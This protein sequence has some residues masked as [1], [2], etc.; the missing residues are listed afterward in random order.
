M[1]RYLTKR[2]EEILAFLI[3]S[4]RD[5]GLPPTITEICER[6]NFSSTNAAHCH[7]RALQ[8]K[9][10]ILRSEKKARD[11]TVTP[12][13]STVLYQTGA[14][15]APLV[16]HVAAGVP[17]LA[18]ENIEDHVPV[19]SD[20]AERG[21]FCLRVRGDSMIEAGILHGDIVVVDHSRR[22]REGDI[23]VALV[24]DDATVKYYHPKGHDIILKPANSAMEPIVADARAVQIQGVVVALQ[25]NF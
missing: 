6:F 5:R 23:V 17:M 24:D 19:A 8:N 21:A 16:G 12:K 7:L 22:P 25:R 15:M 18:E 9:G 1:A 11:I 20:L 3:D 10:Y 14:A 13:A 2:Q 4:I